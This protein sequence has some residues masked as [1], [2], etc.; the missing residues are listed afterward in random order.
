MPS[1]I[2]WW[3]RLLIDL[4]LWKVRLH[5]NSEQAGDDNDQADDLEPGKVHL[6]EKDVHHESYDRLHVV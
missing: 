6:E 5:D 2:L 1:T 3:I 4:L